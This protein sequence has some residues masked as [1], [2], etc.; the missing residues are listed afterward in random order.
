MDI[1]QSSTETN[2][3]TYVWIKKGKAKQTWKSCKM[4]PSK[5]FTPLKY[6]QISVI[7][8]NLVVLDLDIFLKITRLS[9]FN[10][11][12][13]WFISIEY[14]YICKERLVKRAKLD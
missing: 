7:C 4:S 8:D 12:T 1:W 3:I 6:L 10:V 9:C 5:N 2:F 13:N 14:G 11:K